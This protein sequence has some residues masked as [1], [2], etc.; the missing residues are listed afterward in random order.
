MKEKTCNNL[1]KSERTSMKELSKREDIIIAKANKGG[2]N[3]N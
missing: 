3:V 2:A 1:T